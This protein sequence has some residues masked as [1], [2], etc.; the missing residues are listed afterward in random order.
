MK[1]RILFIL[2]VAVLAGVSQVN[3]QRK[4]VGVSSVKI[5]PSIEASAKAD[6]SLLSLQ[7]V[8]EAIDGQ[9]IDSLN[10]TRKFEIIARS[11]LDALL[12]EGGLTGAGLQVGG[13]DYLIVPSIDDFQD[14]I[15]KATFS[16]IGAT[17]EK[18]KIRLGMVARIYD[19]AEG[20][21]I[22]SSSFQ[23][24]NKFAEKLLNNSTRTGSFSDELLRQIAEEMGSKI[25]SRVVDVIYPAKVIMVAGPQVTINRG[26]GTNISSGQV[27][28]IY[29]A[30]EEMIDPDTGESLGSAEVNIG[31]IQ[32]ERVTPKF[33]T[34]KIVEDYGIEKGSIARPAGQ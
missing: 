21:L 5:T 17:A 13:S 18:R 11:D 30:G 8:A 3:A 22:E 12:E 25:S 34:G 27:W 31:K 4:V 1:N 15:E 23:L 9:L 10:G 29:T 32:I 28:S 26:D 19:S 14:L 33:S 2:C 20:T 7:R 16:G 6:N 24:D